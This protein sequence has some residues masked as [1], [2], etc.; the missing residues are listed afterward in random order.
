MT[1]HW[2]K[3]YFENPLIRYRDT[4][5]YA[6]KTPELVCR[7]QE[8]HEEFHALPY[9]DTYMPQPDYE[10]V[11]DIPLGKFK[12]LTTACGLAVLHLVY[13]VDVAVSAL[14]FFCFSK[15]LTKNKKETVR[16]HIN[17]T[18]KYMKELGKKHKLNWTKKHIESRNFQIIGD[19]DNEKGKF[20]IGSSLYDE[21]KGM[22]VPNR[23]ASLEKYNQRVEIQTQLLF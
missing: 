11:K 12:K 1:S 14:F 3:N 10:R 15:L 2:I 13:L 16:D 8:R 23:F 22:I 5:E 17:T 18:A 19:N 20:I 7:M 9:I 6:K 21:N 4:L